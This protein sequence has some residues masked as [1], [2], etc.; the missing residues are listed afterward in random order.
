MTAVL[1]LANWRVG[2]RR[3]LAAAQTSA[4]ERKHAA[5]TVHH[6]LQQLLAGCVLPGAKEALEAANA[7]LA[8]LPQ[9]A[10][11]PST[12]DARLLT[13]IGA[14]ETSAAPGQ[15]EVLHL[16]NALADFGVLPRAVA[17]EW[18]RA[19]AST[20]PQTKTPSPE[21]YLLS[22]RTRL[23]ATVAKIRNRQVPALTA[24]ALETLAS[25][26]RGLTLIVS[27]PELIISSPHPQ[28]LELRHMTTARRLVLTAQGE[29]IVARVTHA[30]VEELHRFE[31]DRTAV[32]W[33][34]ASGRELFDFVS[35]RIQNH[36]FD[37]A[38]PKP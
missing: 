27:L 26:E 4:D 21:E 18:P 34:D 13:I 36:L 5:V 35:E 14:V 3:L 2:A 1:N 15:V 10:A 19:A 30:E 23:R 9:D 33:R 16:V 7:A 25:V 28:Q 8:G 24:L 12:L 6:V 38:P 31:W 11:E 22:G 29:R 20:E 32:R 17:T 37:D